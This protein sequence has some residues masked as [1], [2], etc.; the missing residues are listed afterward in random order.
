M[1]KQS[2][3]VTVKMEEHKELAKLHI[4]TSHHTAKHSVHNNPQCLPRDIV[5][6]RGI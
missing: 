5:G 3:D 1:P 2:E 6:V 4:Y